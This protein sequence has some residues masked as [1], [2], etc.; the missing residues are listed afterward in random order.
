[1]LNDGIYKYYAINDEDGSKIHKG[2]ILIKQQQLRIIADPNGVMSGMFQEG[3]ISSRTEDVMKS[4]NRNGYAVFIKSKP[5]VAPRPLGKAE[6][7]AKGDL[8]NKIR[9]GVAGLALAASTLAPMDITQAKPGIE[10]SPIAQQAQAKQKPAPKINKEKQA[11]LGSIMDVESSNNQNRLHARTPQGGIHHGARAYG[12]YGLM[13][14]TIRETIKKH[15]DLMKEHKA[16]TSMDGSDL[17]NY[18]DKH[19][20]LE[21]TIASRHYDRLAKIFGHDPSKI[22][23]AWIQ[24][25]TGTKRDIKAKEPI[26]NHWHVLKIKDAYE[27]RKKN[28]K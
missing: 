3:P 17:H 18:M 19:P 5:K 8:G 26:Q 7:L 1:M 10:K 27:K 6:D 16:V 22:G 25:I 24:G 2:S 28:I 15:P 12:A 11:I 21:H 9:T 14:I 4:V 23:Y 13:P 20:K